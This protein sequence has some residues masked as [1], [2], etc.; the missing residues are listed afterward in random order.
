MKRKILIILLVM[1]FVVSVAGCKSVRKTK[2]DPSKKVLEINWTIGGYGREYCTKLM[3]A[4]T[5]E[6][7]IECVPT[8]DDNAA[9][10]IA[11]KIGS[12]RKNT[13]DLFFTM[14]PLFTSINSQKNKSGYENLYCELTDLYESNVPGKDI[15]VKDYLKGGIYN[16]QFTD[17]GKL[18]TLPYMA[19]HEGLVYN[20]LVLDKFGITELP[21][22]T[23][24]FEDVLKQIRSGM[25]VDGELV[26]TSTG[27]TIYGLSS[28][29]NSAY[30]AFVWPTWWEQ[31]EGE[32]NIQ[33]YF[34]AKLPGSSD[35]ALP[36][37][38]GLKQPGKLVAIEELNRFINKSKGYVT[39]NHLN[40]DHLFTQIDLLDGKIAFIPTGDWLENESIK[41]YVDAG[42][43]VDVRFMKTPVTSRLAVKYEI[44]EA[45]LREAISYV[46][47]ISEGKTAQKP[48]YK[49]HTEAESET[50]TNEIMKAR[51]LVSSSQI[52]LSNAC[53]PAYS[54]SI[55]AA[56]EFL[57][58]FISD[59]GQKIM[60]EFSH[61]TSPFKYEIEEETKSNFSNFT[62]SAFDI[63]TRDGVSIFIDDFKYPIRYKAG[64]LITYWNSVNSQR[65][66]EEVLYNG[67]K[68]PK[69]VYDYDWGTYKESWDRMLS[70][71][72]Y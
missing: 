50:I 16:S 71:A 36:T 29:C 51:L 13:I 22:T 41:A 18:Y 53:I 3:E 14:V 40:R 57:L 44:T 68:S 52:A 19:P 4:F 62:K 28:A 47:L 64:L 56:K 65:G 54:D 15:K 42:Y 55:D 63:T 39:P 10:I 35:D 31:Y 25:S 11:S 27:E 32:E 49:G 48:S 38:E 60:A 9:S 67:S 17:D 23:D 61:A 43:E 6:T 30:W 1:L 37:W 7:G 8:Y 70:M 72:G 66:F 69:Q 33:N 24:E 5:E 34:K 12:V 20:K 58:F 26:T 46:D 21:R 2:N 59:K 45:E